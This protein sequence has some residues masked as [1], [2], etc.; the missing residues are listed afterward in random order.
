MRLEESGQSR[1]GRRNLV[2]LLISWLVYDDPQ[3]ARPVSRSEAGG[4][5]RRCGL[6][7]SQWPSR[8]ASHLG[9]E[10]CTPAA[11]FSIRTSSYAVHDSGQDS[12]TAAP[13]R[14]SSSSV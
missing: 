9:A 7:Q 4:P 12:A 2:F 10:V 1:G 5:G 6:S 8:S 14:R 13:Q 11:S 3:I